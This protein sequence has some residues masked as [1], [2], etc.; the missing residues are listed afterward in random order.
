MAKISELSNEQLLKNLE[1]YQKILNGLHK[2]RE[3]RVSADPSLK[4]TL[5]TP[6]EATRQAET[7]P[8][9]TTT[10][11]DQSPSSDEESFQ[12]HFKESEIDQI[13]KMTAMEQKASDNEKDSVGMTQVLKLSAEQLEEFNKGN[14]A[15]TPVK[16]TKK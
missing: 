9:A 1:K 12:V 5:F 14:K 7:T 3:R 13:E 10:E 4:K 8:T 15:Q 6:D 11:V 16:K 2:E